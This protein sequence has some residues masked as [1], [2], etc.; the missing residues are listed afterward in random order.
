MDMGGRRKY[1]LNSSIRLKLSLNTIYTIL[2]P[3]VYVKI[4]VTEP[5][6]NHIE[7]RVECTFVFVVFFCGGEFEYSEQ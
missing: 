1:G 2:S 6:F 3:S 7:R 4:I 5:V